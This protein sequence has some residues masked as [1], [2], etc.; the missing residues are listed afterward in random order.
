MVRI[1]SIEAH[2][3]ITEKLEFVLNCYMEGMSEADISAFSGLS[4]QEVKV[5]LN[6]FTRYL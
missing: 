1:K 5:I 3:F 6:E 2:W 4:M